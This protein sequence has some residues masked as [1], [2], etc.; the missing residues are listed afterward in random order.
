MS[1]KMPPCEVR[2]CRSVDSSG[3]VSGVKFARSDGAAPKPRRSA[4]CLAIR[5][6][7]FP[8]ELDEEMAN[9]CICRATQVRNTAAACRMK[10]TMVKT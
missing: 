6:E 2:N 3:D 4:L 10:S 8:D 7:F 5:Q 9:P 1:S